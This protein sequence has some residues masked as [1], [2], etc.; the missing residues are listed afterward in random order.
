LAMQG[1]RPPPAMLRPRQRVHRLPSPH[2]AAA[3]LE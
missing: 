2:L 3:C 1:L